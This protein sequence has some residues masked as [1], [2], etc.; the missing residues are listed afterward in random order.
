MGISFAAYSRHDPI[1][2]SKAH[3][4]PQPFAGREHSSVLCV[5][6]RQNA[7][8]EEWANSEPIVRPSGP[9]QL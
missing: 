8:G 7:T 9:Q 1:F 3:H 6:L 4:H 2:H 5:D